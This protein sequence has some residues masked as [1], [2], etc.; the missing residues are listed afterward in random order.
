MGLLAAAPGPR[1]HRRGLFADHPARTA[2]R[3]AVLVLACVISVYPLVW[4][5]FGSLKSGANFFTGLWGPPSHPV[6]SNFTNAWSTGD[7]GRFL[8][9]S[10]IVTGTTVV[11]VCALGYLLAYAI[12]RMQM[13]GS[14]A[15]LAIFAVSLF[16]PSQLLLI[17]I[18]V[19]ESHAHLLNNYWSLFLPYTAAALPF[20]VIFLVAYLR[21]IPR[22]IEEAAI[23]DGCG[24]LRVLWH[25]MVPLSRPAFATVVI[26]TF[27]GS[28]NEFLLALTLVQT[29]THR[30]LPV[31]LLNFSQAYGPTNYSYVFA[32]LTISAAPIIAVFVVFQ[33]QFI[34]GLTAGAVRM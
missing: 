17:P 26:F 30:T 3:H 18:Y 14:T 9:N 16:V 21:S 15:I 13:R 27:L 12:G 28:W 2:A 8:I 25:I 7:L 19:L 33:K 29:N 23:V 31:G 24:S 34:G 11:L 32:A 4:M 10:V 5:V 22:E 1:R 6:W 20:S